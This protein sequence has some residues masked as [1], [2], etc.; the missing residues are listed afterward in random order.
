[1]AKAEDGIWSVSSVALRPAIY[2]Y[3]FPVNGVR[4]NH[5]SNPLIKSGD[6]T[7]ST[8]FEVKGDKPA[9][10]D[11]QAVHPRDGSHRLLRLEEIRRS[12]DGLGVYATR[13]P[14][15]RG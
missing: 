13:I 1:M 9:P 6:R 11:I 12:A 2:D 3:S 10:Y 8:M 15:P 7:S 14:N 4:T 5:P